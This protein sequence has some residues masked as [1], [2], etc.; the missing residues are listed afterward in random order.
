MKKT[1]ATIALC[2][3]LMCLSFERADG[4]GALVPDTSGEDSRLGKANFA[5][6]LDDIMT[7]LVQPRHIKL[8]Y[9]GLDNNW[10]LASFELQELRSAF[11]RAARTVPRYLDNDMNMAIEAFIQP[12]MKNLENAIKAGDQKV[13]DQA[14]SG[15]VVGCNACHAFLEHSFLVIKVPN[16]SASAS[17]ADQGFNK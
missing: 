3:A 1:A 11:R 2:S 10:E 15:L 13:F 4:Q 17:F 16:A 12:K 5:P 7:L 6:G 9:A 8:Y 14:Y